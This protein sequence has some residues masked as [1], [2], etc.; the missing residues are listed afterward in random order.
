M[1]NIILKD[2]S[3]VATENIIR[4]AHFWVQMADITDGENLLA[5]TAAI[6]PQGSFW[7]P[8][9]TTILKALF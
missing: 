5:G 4:A 2:I 8:M 7:G 6:I 1:D 3:L 9:A